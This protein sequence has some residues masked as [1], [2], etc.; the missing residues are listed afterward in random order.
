MTNDERTTDDHAIR[1][2]L[3]DQCPAID[4]RDD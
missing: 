2:V 3:T 1:T 4:E